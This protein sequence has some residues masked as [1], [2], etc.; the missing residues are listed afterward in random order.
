MVIWQIGFTTK[1]SK[2]KKELSE[3][4]AAILLDLM[5]DIEKSGPIQ[6]EWPH[7]SPLSKDK[8]IP[9]SAFH[10]HIKS[11][12]PTYVVCWRVEDK[13]IKIVE[14]FYVGTHENAPY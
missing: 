7:F 8:R 1:A 5:Q 10:C 13:K 3:D 4:L 11:G 2:Q 14:I 9:A 6:K 12:R